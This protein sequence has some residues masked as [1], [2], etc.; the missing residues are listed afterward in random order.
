MSNYCAIV[1]SFTANASPLDHLLCFLKLDWRFNLDLKL[2][3]EIDGETV[4]ATCDQVLPL[5]R[6]VVRQKAGYI[7]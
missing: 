2:W 5:L 6:R 7:E 3:E 4:R 1:F